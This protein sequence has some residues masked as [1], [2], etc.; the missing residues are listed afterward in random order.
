M[1]KVGKTENQNSASV[2]AALH[3]GEAGFCEGVASLRDFFDEQSLFDHLLKRRSVL[4]EDQ[5]LKAEHLAGC[6][7][8]FPKDFKHSLFGCG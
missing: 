5:V 1:Y 2:I 3:G 7:A 6:D 4:I 8:E